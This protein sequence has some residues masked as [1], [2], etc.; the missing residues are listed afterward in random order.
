MHSTTHICMLNT[1]SMPRCSNCES[2]RCIWSLHINGMYCF[3]DTGYV[4]A[5]PNLLER[6]WNIL[7]IYVCV[8]KYQYVNNKNGISTVCLQFK[9][10]LMTIFDDRMLLNCMHTI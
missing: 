1:H 6:N 5:F 7:L 4:A 2:C 9:Y 8:F 10:Q 3:P